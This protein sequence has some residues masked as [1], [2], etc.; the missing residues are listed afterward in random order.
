MGVRPTFKPTPVATE[1]GGPALASV[2]AFLN[3]DRLPIT[4]GAF[5]RHRAPE[6]IGHR[7]AGCRSRQGRGGFPQFFA[8]LSSVNHLG[9]VAEP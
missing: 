9:N 6:T 4:V 5:V 7:E 8:V 2:L 3:L 1:H